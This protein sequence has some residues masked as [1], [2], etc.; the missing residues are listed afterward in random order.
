MPAR[1]TLVAVFLFFSIITFVIN[2]EKANFSKGN[3]FT[4]VFFYPDMGYIIYQHALQ[5]KYKKV[6]IVQNFIIITTNLCTVTH[7]VIDQ[8][9]FWQYCCLK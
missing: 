9:C 2:T 5:V 1:N 4:F 3:F 7:A 8:K 6:K